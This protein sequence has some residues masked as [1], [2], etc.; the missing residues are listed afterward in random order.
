MLE[1]ATH[2]SDTGVCVVSRIWNALKDAEESRARS[3]RPQPAHPKPAPGPSI[4]HRKTRRSKHQTCLLV[5]GSDS[6]KRP[7]HE[8]TETID[9]NAQGCLISLET[10]VVR[11]QRLYLVNSSNQDGQESRVV[12]VG[13]PVNGRR[14]VAVEFLRAAPEFWFDS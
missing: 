14:E 10:P 8:E 9:A 3:A 13:K 2:L 5:Y 6:A 11:G 12:R 4:E 1:C 7:F